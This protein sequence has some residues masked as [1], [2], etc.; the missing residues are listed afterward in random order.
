MVRIVPIAVLLAVLY[1][2]SQLTKSNEITALRASG[3][4]MVRL[5]MPFMS[6]GL[7]ISILVAIVNETLGPS[8][9]FWCRRFVSE[10]KKDDPNMAYIYKQIGYKNEKRARVWVINEF[11]IRTYEMRN[12]EVVQQ[13]PGGAS[14]EYEVKAKSGRW[15]DGKWWFADVAIQYY[16]EEGHPSGPPRYML[17]REMT[18]FSERPSDFLNEVK[19]PEYLSAK[20]LKRYIRTH[21]QFEE[22]TLTRYAVDLHYRLALPWASFVVS[23]LGVPFGQQTGRKGAFLGVALCL[24]LLGGYYGLSFGAMAL[25]KHMLLAPWLA[26]WLPNIFFFTVGCVMVYRMR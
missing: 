1:A 3:L 10:Q 20:E 14:D 18:E 11:D 9:A 21:P 25:G 4:S 26:G 6:A 2:L 22:S 7:V 23:L 19:D 16:N 13:R 12:V 5:M 17:N 8:S 15:L 24:A